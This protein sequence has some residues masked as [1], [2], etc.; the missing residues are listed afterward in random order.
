MIEAGKSCRGH[1]INVVDTVGRRGHKASLGVRDATLSKSSY[2]WPT[3]A[4]AKMIARH[5]SNVMTYF[6]HRITNP[7]AEG[8]NTKT[9]TIQNGACGFRGAAN[10]KITVDF[11]CGGL[12]LGPQ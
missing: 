6:R 5:L 9:A 3:I 8:S 11:H 10:L 4:T 1:F 2:L 7:M 12:T